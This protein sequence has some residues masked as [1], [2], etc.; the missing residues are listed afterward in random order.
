MDREWQRTSRC[1]ESEEQIDL[2]RVLVSQHFHQLDTPLNDVHPA[3]QLTTHSLY[4]L[5]ASPRLAGVIGKHAIQKLRFLSA[6]RNA[7]GTVSR[8]A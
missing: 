7:V 4:G 1:R 8:R 6:Q 3:L 2:L 5:D